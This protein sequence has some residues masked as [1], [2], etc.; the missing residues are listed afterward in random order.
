MSD[1]P[2]KPRV[3]VS[4]MLPAE[5]SREIWSVCAEKGTTID[6]VLSPSY[7]STVGPQL[8]P[9]ALIEV[10][11]DD[12]AWFAQLLVLSCDRTWARVT[13]LM[14]KELTSADLT[15]PAA[16]DEYRVEFKGPH[17]KHCIIRKK[18]SAIIKDKIPLLADAH[19]DLAQYLKTIAA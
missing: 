14:Y 12:M 17:L 13:M 11:T 10:T 6:E 3:P 2:K 16:N 19:R 9:M 18:D 7:W 5:S 4:R 1:Q 8:R 15:I